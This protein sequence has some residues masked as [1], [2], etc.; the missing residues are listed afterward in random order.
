MAES[1]WFLLAL[2]GKRSVGANCQPVAVIFA[3]EIGLEPIP[4]CLG[5]VVPVHVPDPLQVGG[6]R[7]PH[8]INDVPISRNVARRSGVMAVPFSIPGKPT[9]VRL[10]TPVDQDRTAKGAG[11]LR[12]AAEIFVE[13]AGTD[14]R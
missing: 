5:I 2:R 9:A 11:R 13:A 14:V 7:R 12:P 6:T 8:E 10:Q 1:V 3:R 4:M